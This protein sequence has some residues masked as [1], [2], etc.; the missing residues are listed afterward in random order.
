MAARADRHV[1]DDGPCRTF[2]IVNDCIRRAFGGADAR[3]AGGLPGVRKAGVTLRRQSSKIGA[4]CASERT[5][6]SVRWV[7][8]HCYPYGDL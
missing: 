8:G 4:V 7:A 3:G 5:Y 6:G 2:R 1:E